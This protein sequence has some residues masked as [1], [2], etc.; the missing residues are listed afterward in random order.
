MERSND[1]PALTWNDPKAT[2]K[3]ASFVPPERRAALAERRSEVRGWMSDR[4]KGVER[5]LGSLLG[6]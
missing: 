1:R 2:H 3:L 4:R 5:A 6:L